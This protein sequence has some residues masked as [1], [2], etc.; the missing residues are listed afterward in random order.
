MMFDLA[1]GGHQRVTAG[2]LVVVTWS[3]R[4]RRLLDIRRVR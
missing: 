4:Q 2:D 3:P 1:P